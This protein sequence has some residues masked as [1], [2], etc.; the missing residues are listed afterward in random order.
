MA[1]C[2]RVKEI[3]KRLCST[4]DQFSSETRA[5]TAWADPQASYGAM[6][7]NIHGV[8]DSEHAYIAT[9]WCSVMNLATKC[10]ENVSLRGRRSYDK[11]DVT[12]H[13]AL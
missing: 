12:L 1:K 8:R 6:A 11:T 4:I 2:P 3:A 13:C 9:K 7:M 5:I 10:A